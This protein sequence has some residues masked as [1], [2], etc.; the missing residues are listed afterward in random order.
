MGQQ[1]GPELAALRAAGAGWNNDTQ[2][3]IHLVEHVW[4]VHP[5]PDPARGLSEPVTAENVK[6]WLMK[7]MEWYGPDPI[8]AN[9]DHDATKW[10]VLCMEIVKLLRTRYELLE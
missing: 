2:Q 8:Q 3:A 9:S 5:H 10:F 7:T 6:D 4:R 1:L